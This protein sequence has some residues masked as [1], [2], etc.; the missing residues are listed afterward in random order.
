MRV[1]E[2]PHQLAADVFQP[3]FKMRV[4]I[5]GMVAAEKGGGADVEALLVGDFLGPN[6][7]RRVTGPRGGHGG[8]KRMREGV[9]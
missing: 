4:L 6:Q 1:Q 7:A 5:D 8:V 2:G 9:A 3:E